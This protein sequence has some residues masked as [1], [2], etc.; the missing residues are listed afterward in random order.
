MEAADQANAGEDKNAAHQQRAED[1]PS[2]HFSLVHGGNAK[3]AKQ[4]QE[5]E[6]V[7]D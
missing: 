2:Q 3:V 6:Q 1:S 5:D 4:H 7:I